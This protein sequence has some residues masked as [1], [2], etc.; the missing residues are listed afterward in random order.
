MHA[1]KEEKFPDQQSAKEETVTLY[2]VRE[3]EIDKV[4]TRIY[5]GR[6]PRLFALKLMLVYLMR[7]R[8][9]E[10]ERERN[11]YIEREKERDRER[12]RER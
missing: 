3:R 10:R 6:G 8:E 1:K 12:E 7:E 9:R 11:I 4:A 5:I 2:K